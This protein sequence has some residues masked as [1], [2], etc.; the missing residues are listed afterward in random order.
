MGKFILNENGCRIYIADGNSQKRKKKNRFK[1]KKKR[2]IILT[3]PPKTSVEELIYLPD[4]KY[5]EKEGL[6]HRILEQTAKDFFTKHFA[7]DIIDDHCAY[8]GSYVAADFLVKRNAKKYK[9]KPRLISRFYLVECLSRNSMTNEYVD[10]KLK[11]NK[12]D[13]LVFVVPNII[14]ARNLLHNF[15]RVIFVNVDFSNKDG[16]IE[17]ARIPGF[18]NPKTPQSTICEQGR[19]LDREYDA[20]VGR[21]WRSNH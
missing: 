18:T 2:K 12:D 10:K 21:N 8:R 5:K 13:R 17:R 9:D 16:D 7:V 3:S 20:I 11:L 4:P 1:Q 15:K 6:E 14:N 19:E